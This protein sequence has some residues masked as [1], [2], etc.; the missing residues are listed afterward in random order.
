MSYAIR[1]NQYRYLVFQIAAICQA[2]SGKEGY[3][4]LDE[5]DE[6]YV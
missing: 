2:A 3:N 1:T 6:N 5:D 4:E